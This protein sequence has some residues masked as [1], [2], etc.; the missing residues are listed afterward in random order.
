M[1][2]IA[3]LL[4]LLHSDSMGRVG[5][6]MGSGSNIRF[7]ETMRFVARARLRVARA[8]MVLMGLGRFVCVLTPIQLPIVIQIQVITTIILIWLPFLTLSYYKISKFLNFDKFAAA[9]SSETRPTMVKMV[10]GTSVY[11]LDVHVICQI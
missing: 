4:I 8:A 1:K 6:L 11:T 10:A 2:D 5:G 3:V 7:K 9:S